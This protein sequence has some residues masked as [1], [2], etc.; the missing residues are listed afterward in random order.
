[1]KIMM[2]V[3]HVER[4]DDDDDDDGDD[5]GDEDDEDDDGDAWRNEGWRRVLSPLVGTTPLSGWQT[6]AQQ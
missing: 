2:M 4:D 1:M 6:A 5:N 3:T